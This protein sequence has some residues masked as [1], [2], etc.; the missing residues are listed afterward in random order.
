MKQICNDDVT[1]IFDWLYLGGVKNTRKTLPLVD[2]WYDFKWD[3]RE[4]KKI[5]YTTSF[6]CPSHS[7]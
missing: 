5:T 2:V 7:V 6:A 1:P 3:M 4:P